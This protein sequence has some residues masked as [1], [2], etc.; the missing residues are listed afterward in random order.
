MA[1]QGWA[2]LPCTLV[3][4]RNDKPVVS[5][6]IILYCTTD[7]LPGNINSQ[8]DPRGYC[9]IRWPHAHKTVS[10]HNYVVI[11]LE[12]LKEHSVLRWT[13]LTPSGNCSECTGHPP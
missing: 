10:A 2:P 3:T 13:S 5:N 11:L 12:A 1:G 9:I 6:Q 7:I 4:S 8:I